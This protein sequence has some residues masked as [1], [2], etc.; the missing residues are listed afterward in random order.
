MAE[1]ITYGI[2]GVGAYALLAGALGY[3]FNQ[4]AFY[5]GVMSV[6]LELEDYGY[7]RHSKSPV[8]HS[9][10]F[11]ILWISCSYLLLSLIGSSAANELTLAIASAFISHFA[12]DTV[13]KEGIFGY[14]LN[15]RPRG[16]LSPLP[17][18]SERAW[19]S[20]T[21]IP[22]TGWRQRWAREGADPILNIGSTMTSMLI[23][24]ASLA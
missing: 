14:P 3:P 12:L 11:A 21:I 16:W 19:P 13:S 7:Q 23:I 8:T 2:V 10:P 6:I 9:L 17:R 18:N 20:W 15:G 22:G 5:A 24:I 4:H 1:K